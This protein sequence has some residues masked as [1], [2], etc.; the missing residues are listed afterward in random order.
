VRNDTNIVTF[1]QAVGTL[2]ACRLKFM[3]LDEV[4]EWFA[5]K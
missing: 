3:D 4:L 5:L 1:A 2:R